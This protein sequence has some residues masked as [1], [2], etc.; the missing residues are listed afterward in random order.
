MVVA[1]LRQSWL[2]NGTLVAVLTRCC[3]LF[4]CCGGNGVLK[5]QTP[6]EVKSMDVTELESRMN[7][8]DDEWLELTNGYLFWAAAFEITTT[9]T[10]TV[11]G[12]P[13]NKA[14]TI[15][16]VYVPLISKITFDN[17]QAILA[18]EGA[19]AN[20]PYKECR[21]VVK[22]AFLDLERKYPEVAAALN[23][24][25]PLQNPPESHALQGVV[26]RLDAEP[27]FVLEASAVTEGPQGMHLSAH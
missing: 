15:N 17:W 13:I 24:K 3:L 25:T 1:K 2:E 26:S 27:T 4:L 5:N 21:V 10:Q 19:T 6:P 12:N 8:P 23:K 7:L 16:E 22:F 20:L 14:T 9:T 11:F 18:K